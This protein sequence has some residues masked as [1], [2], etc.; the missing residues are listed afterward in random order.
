VLVGSLD[1]QRRPWASMLVGL[2]GFM[3]A[4]DER[5]LRI[6]AQPG[7]GDPLREHLAVG[8]PLGLLGIE[9]H[10]RRR[11]RM[12]GTLTACDAAGFTVQVD[13][14]FGNC[15]QYIQ[16]R[17]PDWV[18]T[19][20][21]FGHARTVI[22]EGALL[23][24]PARRLAA[25]SDTLYIATAARQARAHGGAYGADVSHRGGKPGFVRVNDEGEGASAR[26]V[27]TVPDFR[28]NFMFAT[29]GNI[30]DHPRAG[31]LFA[32][33]DNGDLLQLTGSAEIVWDG[34]AVEAFEGA[35]RLLRVSVEASRWMPAAL[36][37]RWSA[38]EYAPQL[39]QT[40][41]WA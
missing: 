10:T 34:P 2:P 25:R 30:A 15:P 38:P 18:D 36:P 17:A 24:L 21:S 7:F 29:L 33:P 5:H 4:P 9:P 37:L 1:A 40:G 22:A 12:N 26:T 20:E 13:Q 6:A 14:S 28:G 23:G 32:D 8:A 16:A 31:L 27:L 39:A 11:N 35:Q 3:S 19:P 41:V